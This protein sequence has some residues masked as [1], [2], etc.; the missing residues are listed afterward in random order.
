VFFTA[1]HPEVGREPWVL[2]LA[3]L[4]VASASRFARGCGGGVLTMPERPRLGT[5]PELV[6][7]RA[8][9][10]VAVAVV[11]S[12]HS[13]R[14]PLPDCELRVGSELGVVWTRTDGRGSA[15]VPIALPAARSLLGQSL[16]V[17]ALAGATEPR[18][19]D[20]LRLVLGS[21]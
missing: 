1:I 2:P 21:R 17:Q 11:W 8:E 16:F 20:A 5:E 12:W 3:D 18:A 6:L 14:L 13:T 19:S 15:R 7:A 4:E 10:N 9:S